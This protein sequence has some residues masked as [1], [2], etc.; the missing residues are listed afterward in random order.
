MRTKALTSK[1]LLSTILAITLL[2]TSTMTISSR[3][4]AAAIPDTSW[5]YSN[6]NSVTYTIYSADELA[7][8]AQLV[9]NSDVDF[10]GKT[11]Y[12]GSDVDLTE[13]GKNYDEGRGWIPIGFREFTGE[14]GKYDG[15]P[16]KGTFDGNNHKITGGCSN[17]LW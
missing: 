14:S 17:F 1:Q 5:Y 13:Y 7:G 4:Q 16:F 15:K 12:L 3:T 9:N 6:E 8:L 10:E 2:L 11:I